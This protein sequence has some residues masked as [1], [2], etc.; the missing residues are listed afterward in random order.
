MRMMLACW[1]L[2]CSGALSVSVSSIAAMVAG[3]LTKS[4]AVPINFAS[5]SCVALSVCFMSVIVRPDKLML[6][7][8]LGLDRKSVV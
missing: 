1:I 6:Y 4:L 7:T 3:S 5:D 2:L 8:H